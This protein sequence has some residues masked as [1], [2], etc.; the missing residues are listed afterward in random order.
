[1]P[2]RPVAHRSRQIA[3]R[4][5]VG[6]AVNAAVGQRAEELAPLV[7]TVISTSGARAVNGRLR[8]ERTVKRRP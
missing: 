6:V 2:E 5:G 7:P 1:V 3:R 4:D 8:I